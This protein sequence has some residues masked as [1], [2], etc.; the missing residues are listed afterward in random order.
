MFPAGA[1]ARVLLLPGDGIGP[2]VTAAARAVLEVACPGIEY[3]ERPVGLAALS[4]L[5]VPFEPDLIRVAKAHDAILF[6][7]V[8]GPTHQERGSRRPEEAL[9]A[10]RRELELYANLRP[11]RVGTAPLAGSPL[12]PEYTA[13]VDLLL[14]RELAGG[15]YFGEKTL[16]SESASDLCAYSRHEIARV[17]RQAFALARKRRC[18]VASVDKANVM[19]TGALWRSVVDE[20]AA[21]HD[22]VEVEHLLVDNAAMQLLLRAASFD[23][24]VTENLFGDILSDEVS[25]LVGGLGMVP[26]AS[27]GDAPPALYEPAHGSAP[28][29]AGRGLANPC[30]AILSAA[31]LVRHTLGDDACATAIEQAVDAAVA[32]GIVTPDLGGAASTADVTSAVIARLDG[33]AATSIKSNSVDI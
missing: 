1:P 15:L 11:I 22:D 16:N 13:G 12:R 7:A 17:V 32:A 28:D 9:F 8:G 4:S 23:V 6:G 14:L 27:F 29:I 26:S 19:A 31:L 24:V 33:L 20:L 25:L 21:E 5:G 2:E 18:R 10:L 3:T 30:A